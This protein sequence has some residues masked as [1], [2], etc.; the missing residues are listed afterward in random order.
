MY[1]V[2]SACLCVIM[3]CKQDLK[4]YL[5]DLHKIYNRDCLDTTLEM[6]NF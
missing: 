6:I 5:I 4:Q 2:A 3:F 1:S